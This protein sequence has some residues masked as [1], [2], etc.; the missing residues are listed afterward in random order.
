MKARVLKVHWF[1]RKLWGGWGD[2]SGRWHWRCGRWEGPDV[3][4]HF[5]GLSVIDPPKISNC[6]GEVDQ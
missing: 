2:P 6:R 5:N 4:Y 1:G 3:V